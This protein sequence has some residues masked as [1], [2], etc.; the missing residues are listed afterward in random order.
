MKTF[1]CIIKYVSPDLDALLYSTE[2][3]SSHLNIRG[4]RNEPPA[5]DKLL[6]PIPSPQDCLTPIDSNPTPFQELCPIQTRSPCELDYGGG[7]GLCFV[8]PLFLQDY[9]GRNAMRRRHHFKSSIK[10]RVSTEIPAPCHPLSSHHLHRH[11][12]LKPKQSQLKAAKQMTP[13]VA[14]QASEEA[15]KKIVEEATDYMD[16]CVSSQKKVKVTSTLSP[17]AEED[18]YQMPKALQKVRN[19]FLGT[20]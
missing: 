17:T 9:T 4:P 2:F 7:K 8:N 16:P 18:D 1:D 13:P 20:F 10:V 14:V 12:W 3:W 19:L 11:Y 6:P 15:I 5:T